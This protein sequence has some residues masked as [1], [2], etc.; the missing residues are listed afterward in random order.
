MKLATDD[1][2]DDMRDLHSKGIGYMDPKEP[3]HLDKQV[4]ATFPDE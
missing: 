3:K 4:V 2:L 1:F